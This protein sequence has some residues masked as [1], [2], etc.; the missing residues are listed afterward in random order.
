MLSLENN[1]VLVVE[2][3]PNPS[4]DFF[5]LPLVRRWGGECVRFSFSD[6]PRMDEACE[7]IVIFVRYIPWQW[8]KLLAQH[9]A[10]EVYL[11]IDDDLLDFRAWA[12]L[13]VH[14]QWKLFR[15]SYIHQRWLKS[16]GG[17]L[18]VSN[19]YLQQK[20]AQ[21][22]AI[23]IEPKPVAS[24]EKDT[25]I[26]VFYHGS[27]SHKAD[28]QWLY[29]VIE[30]V[31]T[32]NESV[33]FQIIG[34]ASV[35]KQFRCLE[36]VNVLHPMPWVTYRQFLKSGRFDIGLAPLLDSHFNRARSYTKF[37][38]ITMAGAVGIYTQNS[39]YQDI[40]QHQVNG[41]LLPMDQQVWAAELSALVSDP[42]LRAQ[43]FEQASQ[44]YHLSEMK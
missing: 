12:G 37:F 3:K 11:F 9:S 34:D 30:S 4:T 36:R 2:E 25:Q 38:D 29:P 42:V 1:R 43:L 24:T 19:P 35:N 40:V 14:Y 33:C 15:L 13:P 31:I 44:T 26:T 21:W 32:S 5:I 22:G 6:M 8:K 18:L 20:Y 7:N 16:I 17:K 39:V 41:L 28:I 27:G 10:K 23:G